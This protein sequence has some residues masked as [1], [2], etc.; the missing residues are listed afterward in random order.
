[1]SDT[2]RHFVAEDTG[3]GGSLR[4][5]VG[6]G[7]KRWALHGWVWEW[8]TKR[9]WYMP[10]TRSHAI[11]ILTVCGAGGGGGGEQAA[12][13]SWQI[14]SWRY[15]ATLQLN[16][17]LPTF[18]IIHE[19]VWVCW[20]PVP[21]TFFIGRAQMV[22]FGMWKFLTVCLGV[23]IQQPQLRQ[24]AHNTVKY[25]VW[26]CTNRDVDF[27]T[28]SGRGQP[29]VHTVHV[30]DLKQVVHNMKTFT[31]ELLNGRKLPTTSASSLKKKKDVNFN[32]VGNYP[33]VGFHLQNPRS[34]LEVCAVWC[35]EE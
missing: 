15:V 28:A 14:Y 23:N 35:L 26:S 16:L 17:D 12:T 33:V 4:V 10:S 29:I 34:L 8:R 30:A 13:A 31:K 6:E 27:W 2:D 19:G 7:V 24:A 9:P 18:V 3:G 21:P 32:V 5:C 11:F 22:R 20:N 1:M 25:S